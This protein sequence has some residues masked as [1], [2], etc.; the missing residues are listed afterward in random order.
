MRNRITS[1]IIV[2][3]SMVIAAGELFAQ[4]PPKI[5][6]PS[7]NAAAFA[8]YGNIPVSTYTGLP[9]ISIPIYEIR[10]RDIVVPISLSYHASG[11]KVAEE[12]SQ[13]GL[14]WT[15]NTGGMISRNVVNQD[16]F[17]ETIWAYLNT[18]NHSPVFPADTLSLTILK[19]LQ[20][21]VNVK[22]VNLGDVATP[23]VYNLENY[24]DGQEYDFEPDQFSFNFVGNSGK[25]MLRR[26]ANNTIEPVLEKQ[27][28]LSISVNAAGT[29]FTVKTPDGASYLFN[30]LETYRSNGEGE[31]EHVSAWYLS[32]IT[33]PT[34]AK[35]YFDYT[36]VTQ[37][38]KPVG[39]FTETQQAFMASCVAFTCADFVPASPGAYAPGKTYKNVRLDR[40]R[41]DN[42]KV[43]FEMGDRLDVLGDKKVESMRVYANDLVT[44][45]PQL[46]DVYEFGYQ[47]FSDITMSPVFPVTDVDVT[48]DHLTK[49]LK[50]VSIQRKSPDGKTEYK[51][52]FQYYESGDV[53]GRL[54]AKNSYSRDHWGYYNG[55]GKA[56]FLPSYQRVAQVTSLEMIDGVMGPERDPNPLYIKAASLKSI[57]YPTGGTTEFEYGIN[58]YD[59]VNTPSL[60]E[61]EEA[62]PVYQPFTQSSS[63]A[64]V[65][66]TLDVR[67]QFQDSFG[68]TIPVK[69]SGAFTSNLSSCSIAGSP[70][71]YVAIMSENGLSELKKVSVNISACSTP[72]QIDCLSCNGSGS[73]HVFSFVAFVVL[74]PGIYKWKGVINHT[75]FTTATTQVEW[76]ADPEKRPR[77]SDGDPNIKYSLTGGLRVEKIKDFD[78][79]SGKL[80]NVRTFNYHTETEEGIFS[81]GIRMIAPRYSYNEVALE[82]KI[83]DTDEEGNPGTQSAFCLDCL[84]IIRQSDSFLPATGS[85]GSI[86][87]YSRVVETFGEEGENGST[88][89]EYYNMKDIV[90]E[91]KYEL[92][93]AY[94]MR[95]PVVATKSDPLNGMLLSQTSYNSEG[96][97]VHRIVNEYSEMH[98]RW[99]YGIEVRRLR[100][101]GMDTF[102]ASTIMLAFYPNIVKAPYQL[103]VYPVIASSFPYQKNTKE[104]FY[105]ENEL[106][107]YSTFSEYTYG[108]R[109]HLQMIS[110]TSQR[111]NQNVLLTSHKYALDYSQSQAD[112]AITQMKGASF[113]HSVPIE[114]TTYDI[115]AGKV[116]SHTIT[117]FG[118]FGTSILP[119]SVLNLN[120][121]LAPEGVP[122]YVPSVGYNKNLY[123]KL[124]SIDYN[125]NGTV[126]TVQKDKDVPMCY[127]WGIR[128]S[129]PVAEIVNAEV[130]EVSL[131]SFE[132][133]GVNSPLTPHT[134]RRYYSGSYPVTFV[135]PNT[136]AYILEYW[137]YASSKWNHK[138]V[139]Y[140]G[141]ITLT[142]GSAY[143]DVRV[144]PKDAMMK[145][146]TYDPLGE[147]TSSI[148]ENGQTK[149][150]EYDTFGRLT[151]IRNEKGEIE[152]QY[153][154][155]YKEQ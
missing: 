41:W 88:V 5:I 90:T 3:A 54:P 110:S 118:Q 35:V 38:I 48:N 47:Y 23:T 76:W 148:A 66:K 126:K 113:I 22:F 100:T 95:P 104:I 99:E 96:K 140:T 29:S 133:D 135:I 111:S 19:S 53:Y 93:T 20:S 103:F 24:I 101:T 52:K 128:Q 151:R 92:N 106:E 25:F 37:F 40:I 136:R 16:D 46:R 69:L 142:D 143:D 98:R 67:D 127:L 146:F 145:S 131:K 81:S 109:N 4:A 149:I 97:K 73:Y 39:V 10:N 32:D 58:D 18:N 112:A 154:Y 150:L 36:I 49:R 55:S 31:V 132:D 123:R 61:P 115:T 85:M 82:K 30:V 114:T 116:L 44:G 9:N 124:Y 51:H 107:K 71:V 102:E 84:Y 57:T 33:S 6:P 13:V 75:D 17:A 63:E 12:A 11:I 68:S 120:T 28:K 59:I 155:H 86:V 130:T 21:G 129:F 122:T 72:G 77:N 87:G 105:D 70:D 83:L 1:L 80:S 56:S 89:Y 27:Q 137:Y 34:G 74:P 153:T 139:D 78:P 147:M 125:S 7:P 144:Y 108:G 117:K 45:Q 141:P 8:K 79:E 42:G 2:T 26:N 152:K 94:K 43:E 62:Y 121:P 14:G 60:P 64:T 91:F 50:L 138:V 65:L 119:S 15:L 134:G